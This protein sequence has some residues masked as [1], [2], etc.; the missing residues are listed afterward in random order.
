MDALYG[1]LGQNNLYTNRFGKRN[2]LVKFDQLKNRAIMVHRPNQSVQ[3]KQMKQQPQLSRF[4]V[5]FEFKQA[6]CFTAISSSSINLFSL[7]QQLTMLL[8]LFFSIELNSDWHWKRFRGFT[9]C[10]DNN[11]INI[12]TT[13]TTT[14]VAAAATYV[15]ICLRT[16]NFTVASWQSHEVVDNT[17]SCLVWSLFT[18]RWERVHEF[19]L[20]TG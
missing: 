12:A 11:N 18:C 15:M 13:T 20:E 14:S 1:S 17:S 9:S 10:C 7:L 2:I 3:V 6:K 8:A 16:G 19:A 4:H 5:F